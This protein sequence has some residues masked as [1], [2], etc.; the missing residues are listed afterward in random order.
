MVL[1]D[2]GLFIDLSNKYFCTLFFSR[3]FYDYSE[4]YGKNL[5]NVLVFIKSV[6]I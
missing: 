2:T 6:L 5:K 3:I 4:D 1:F